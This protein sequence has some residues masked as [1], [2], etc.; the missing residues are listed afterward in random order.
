MLLEMSNK[1]SALS[2]RHAETKFCQKHLHKQNPQEIMINMH[3]TDQFHVLVAKEKI[4]AQQ[5]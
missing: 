2:L 3:K 5:I 4:C 1:I